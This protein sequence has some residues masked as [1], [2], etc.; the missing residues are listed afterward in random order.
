[1]NWI[2]TQKGLP[3]PVV[4]EDVLGFFLNGEMHV[5][6]YAGDGRWNR[7]MDLGALWNVPAYWALLPQ[8]PVQQRLTQK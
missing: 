3:K 4:G 5:I 1:M 6:Y 7:R 8:E 2:E